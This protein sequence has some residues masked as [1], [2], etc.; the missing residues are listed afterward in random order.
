MV[1]KTA[2]QSPQPR[3]RY[4]TDRLKLAR[5]ILRVVEA[6]C[7]PPVAVI[8]AQAT[9]GRLKRVAV[10]IF[11]RMGFFL[12]MVFVVFLVYFSVLFSYVT[13]GCGLLFCLS[14]S[15]NGGA[16]VQKGGFGDLRLV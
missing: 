7:E 15:R 2:A 9:E 11:Q 1:P 14:D 5:G 3:W 8:R 16:G 10:F 12:D 13:F 6:L 4:S